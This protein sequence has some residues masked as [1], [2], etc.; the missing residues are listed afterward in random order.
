M[1]LIYNNF[2][3]YRTY[4]IIRV[5]IFYVIKNYGQSCVRENMQ[6]DRILVKSMPFKSLVALWLLLLVICNVQSVFSRP[7]QESIKSRTIR[8]PPIYDDVVSIMLLTCFKCLIFILL[9][10][11]SKRYL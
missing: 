7:V 3:F 5:L 8:S 1:I 11:E 9:H 4:N 6:T 2:V 10:Y